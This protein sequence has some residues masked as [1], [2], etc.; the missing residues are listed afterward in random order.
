ML[1]I[2][3]KLFPLLSPDQRKAFYSLQIL[4]M[5]MAI[6]EILGIASIVP[7]MVLVGDMNILQQDTIFARFYQASDLSSEAHFVFLT[8][9]AVLIMLF[10]SSMISMFTLWRLSI[11]ATKTGSEL[12]DQLYTHYIRQGWLFHSR[13][14]SA[15]LTKKIFG[16]TS[17]VSGQIILP[18]MQMNARI[19]LALLLSIS[20]FIYDPKVAIIGVSVF[21]IAYTILFK[22]I[23]IRLA[24]NGK[25]ISK[26][27]ETR[28]RLINHGFGGIKDVLLFGRDRHFIKQF[29]KSGRTLA[30]SHASNTALAQAP[31]FFMEL[32]AFGTIISLVLY[33]FA[34][35]KGDMIMI[36]PILSVYTLA[37]FKLLP[38][39]QQ[40][41]VCVATIKGNLSAFETIEQDLV[42][43][44]QIK[45]NTFKSEDGSLH[46]KQQITLENIS[47]TYPGNFSPAINELSMSIPANSLVGIVGPSGSGKTTLID[48]LLGLITP[49]QGQLKVDSISVDEENSRL[50]KNTIGFVPQSIF[51]SEG[52]IVQNVAFGIPDDKINIEKVKN[53]LTLSHLDIFLQSLD[54]GIYTEVGE[55]GVQLSGGQR[56]RIGIARALYHNAKVL[57]FDEA[58]S[59]LDGITEKN[60]MEAI[61]NFS[62]QKTII[63][64]AHRLKT[65][66]KCDQIFLVDKGK[67]TDHGT[68]E[69]L[70]KRNKHFKDMASHA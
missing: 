17:R 59:S 47:F 32:V 39:F 42:D 41:F 9:V 29:N 36:L 16:E 61:H 8:G 56:Q 31:R 43:S 33:L 27:N 34:T 6:M 10:I 11:F 2:I 67:I 5:L 19:V 69:E 58:T 64:V 24:R 21:A 3:K 12:A 65:V 63:M 62:G 53:A 23:R 13:G 20:I 15:Q 44:A 30:Y 66:Q 49:Q 46:L 54:K 68:Y 7:F 18:L 26:V 51:L 52:T 60:I 45:S 28:Y 25:E 22:V 40:I 48:I 35:H 38:A 1:R 55:R 4:V 50:W 37:A 57:V 70:L 14:S